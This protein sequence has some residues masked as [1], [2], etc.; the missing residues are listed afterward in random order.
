MSD[1]GVA[2][3]HPLRVFT[4]RTELARQLRRRRTQIS[5]GLLVVLPLVL[6]LAF[7][8]GGNPDDTG[9]QGVTLVDVATSGGLNFTLFSIFAAAG[10]LLMVV[11]ALFCGDTVAGEASWG[12]LRY[13]LAA[14]VPRGRLLRTKLLVGALTSLGA[15]VLLPAVALAVGT[16]AYGWEPL[17]TPLGESIAP[18]A[19]IIRL[20]LVIA[21]IA[22][23]LAW[24][25]S[26][27][28]LLSVSTDAPLGA[29]GGAVLLVIVSNIL[30]TI[31]ALGD[32]RSALPTRY[33]L[34]WLDLLVTPTTTENLAK[35][36][37]SSLIYSTIFLAA[38]WYRFQRKD[39]VS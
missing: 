23:S 26:L 27:A 32:L 18:G 38:A 4:V 1:V 16:L 6:W 29:V 11:V 37:V 30:E 9:Q 8:L 33:S 14:P 31:T 36:C 34:A 20:L 17:R 39:I 19:A 28:F 25:G 35:G 13:L 12:S 24:V 22:V 3:S 15:L 21:Y 5:A 7:T 2:W 10:F